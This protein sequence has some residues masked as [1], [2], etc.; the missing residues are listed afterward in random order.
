MSASHSNP[1]AAPLEAWRVHE[2]LIIP[3]DFLMSISRRDFVKAGVTAATI[4]AVP[5]PLLIR[6]G[7][8]PE[9]APQIDD[10]RFKDLLARALDAARGAGATYAD[11]RLTHDRARQVSENGV[12]DTENMVV[13]V[14]ALFDGYW[15]FASGPVWSPDEMA[16][17]G[18]E[19][20]HQAKSNTLGKTRVVE[21]ASAPAVSSGHWVMPVR[22]D[23]FTVSPTEISDF[24]AGLSVYVS[25]T[26]GTNVQVNQCHLFTQERAFGSTD[27]SYITQRVHRT[28]GEFVVSLTKNGKGGA[29]ELDCLSPTGIGWELYRDQPLRESIRLLLAEIEADSKLPVKPLDV[30]RYDTAFDAFGV[31]NAIDDT[32]GHATELDRAM[33]YEANAGGTSY[34]ND[35]LEMLGSYQAGAPNLTVTGNRTEQGGCATVQWDDEGVVPDEFLL[36]Q[37]GVLV[38]F[39]TTRESAGWLKG[40]YARTKKPFRS[41]GCAAAPSGIFAPLQHVPNLTLAPGREALDFDALI[42][43]MSDGIAIK[44]LSLNMD[45][46]HLNGLG[47]GRTYEVKRGKRTALIA[48][49]AV[50]FRAPELWKGLLAVG[51]KASQRRFG[52]AGRKGEPLQ[53]AYYSVTA[54]PAV[55]KQL[56]LIDPLRKA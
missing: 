24:L 42:G 44:D 56:T 5:R 2:H 9:V 55:F 39:Q 46:Q 6:L 14:R 32:L 36:V 12:S 47:L 10:P 25:R 34:L 53:Q 45:F 26:P 4:A 3:S 48:G 17:L 13:G 1:D 37:D 7:A 54:P 30:G 11:V 41:H 33:G 22:I 38:D 50:L 15:G 21:M 35:P 51:G 8:K 29:G 28:S 27:G 43:G 40:Y 31:G 52:K 19:A 20:V 16:R 23:P 18:R 49:A